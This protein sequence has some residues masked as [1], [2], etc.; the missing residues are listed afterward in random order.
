MHKA[1]ARGRSVGKPNAEYLQSFEPLTESQTKVIVAAAGVD[2]CMA[3]TTK[4]TEACAMD[5]NSR[6]EEK[7][8]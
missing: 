8:A 6:M 4:I 7:A 1:V 3:L 5:A 2:L